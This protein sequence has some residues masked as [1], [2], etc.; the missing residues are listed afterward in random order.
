VSPGLAYVVIR[1]HAMRAELIDP[2]AMRSLAESRDMEEFLGLLSQT[3]Y[4]EIIEEAG[5]GASAV[6]LERVFH[7]KLVERLDRVIRVAPTGMAEFLRVYY[8]MRLEVQNLKR[9]L[10]GKSSEAP[11]ERIKRHLIPVSPY[12]S[13]DFDDLV[14]AETIADSVN[15][16]GKTVYAPIKK[17]LAL[18]EKYDALWPIEAWLNQI[19]IESVQESLSKISS[20]DRVMVR[21]IVEVETDV[22]N[23]LSA[24][25]WRRMARKQPSLPPL[26]SIFPLTYGTSLRTIKELIEGRDPGDVVRGLGAPYAEIL[27]PIIDDDVALVRTNLHKH[28]YEAAREGRARDDF[29]FPCV[30]SYLV[31]CD[32]ERGDLV[33]I[34]WGK[35]HELESKRIL[36]YTVLPDYAA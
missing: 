8:Y 17:G 14:G 20:E 32:I 34:A 4:Q 22:E 2:E 28:I 30:M 36:K 11:I 5:D 35:E 7:Q 33:S 10:R 16:L 3:R 25:N 18:C 21:Q 12:L 31:S 26:E 9:I 15:L 24:I 13:V 27:E 23:L 1:C 19:Y 29:G 6:A